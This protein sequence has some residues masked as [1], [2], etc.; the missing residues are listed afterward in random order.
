MI[1]VWAGRCGP[2]V[3][4]SLA[5]A[6]R[7][8]V[9]ATAIACA[10]VAVRAETL[11]DALVAAYLNSNLLEQN[12][13]L[14]RAA[15]EDVA[16]AIAT[17]R[18]V[19][20]WAASTGRRYNSVLGT[21]DSTTLELTA[22]ITI[23]DFGR[24]PLAIKAAK[25]SVLAGRDALLQVEQ[26]V[27]LT[28]VQAYM[29]VIRAAR[30][31][32][33]RRS[34]VRL[35]TSELRAARE[36]FAVGEVTRTDVSIAEARLAASRSALTAAEGDYNLAREAYKAA[37]GH[38]PKNLVRPNTP[39]MAARTVDEARAIAVKTHP[40]ILQRQRE[41]TVAELNIARAKA[42]RRP[43]IGASAGV[44]VDQDNTR[45]GNVTLSLSQT[46]YSGGTLASLIRQ[47]I[48]RAE[49]DRAEL[50]QAVVMVKQDVAGAWSSL[51]VALASTAASQQQVAASLSAYNGTREEA[52]LGA[53]TTLDVLNAEQEL[54]D[55]RAALI[56]SEIQQFVAVYTL[57]STMGLLT[58]KHLDLGL[59]TYDAEAYYNAVDGA[60][61]Y[62][63][64]QGEKLD[65]LLK[66]LGR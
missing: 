47:A 12:R 49:G 52:E 45:T 38:Y 8:L 10:G 25:E 37:I 11:T 63:S 23:F 42:D 27:L 59:V 57:L 66:S 19:L 41:V 9:A 55:A 64:P 4:R 21:T 48:A 40:L 50:L 18:P 60:P 56:Q 35:I 65:K 22:R 3:M 24:T 62:V 16:Q 61:V 54:L 17:L 14:L 26:N 2:R 29:E 32:E 34:N 13:A 39:P 36:R 1:G 20:A 7:V 44:G 53:R 30:F 6:G 46:I 51:Q 28:A 31:V 33:L 43:T 58:A 5:R 15:D